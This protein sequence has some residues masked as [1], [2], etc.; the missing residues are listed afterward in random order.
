MN[1]HIILL[2]YFDIIVLNF[3]DDTF[4]MFIENFVQEYFFFSFKRCKAVTLS[5]QKKY[6]SLDYIDRKWVS[7]AEEIF[8]SS[9]IIF[10]MKRRNILF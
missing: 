2:L 6:S 3:S 9:L 4:E 10:T 1:Y 7:T 8:L 5:M